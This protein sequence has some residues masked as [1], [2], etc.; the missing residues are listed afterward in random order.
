MYSRRSPVEV[1]LRLSRELAAIKLRQKPNKGRKYIS[2]WDKVRSREMVV[3]M[4]E[5]ENVAEQSCSTGSKVRR[6]LWSRTPL[7]RIP[8]YPDWLGCSGKFVGNSTKLNLSWSYRLSDQVQYSVMASG[9]TNQARSKGLDAGTQSSNSRTSNCQC[10]VV[11]KK[12][13]PIIRIFCISGWL[14]ASVNP[15]NW[16]SPAIPHYKESEKTPE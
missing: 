16:S 7:I 2:N 5:R 13:N 12:K 14:G 10:S 15:D 3:E 1:N 4:K 11:S 8:N 6:F 9:T